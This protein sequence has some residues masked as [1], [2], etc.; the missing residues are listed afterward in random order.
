MDVEEEDLLASPT[1]TTDVENYSKPFTREKCSYQEKCQQFRDARAQD[2]NYGQQYSHIY[3]T[4]LQNMKKMVEKKARE[5][6]GE[7]LKRMQNLA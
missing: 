3:Y 6:W 2:K 5:K 4:R 1:S 7:C